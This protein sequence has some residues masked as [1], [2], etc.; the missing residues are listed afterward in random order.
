MSS[1]PWELLPEPFEVGR[2]SAPPMAGNGPAVRGSSVQGFPCRYY[3]RCVLD[4]HCEG[5][6][7]GWAQSWPLAFPTRNGRDKKTPDGRSSQPFKQWPDSGWGRGKGEPYP[8]AAEAYYLHG[9][10]FISNLCNAL[11]GCQSEK[12]RLR[13]L[14]E[15]SCQPAEPDPVCTGGGIRRGSKAGAPILLNFQ[16]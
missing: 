4:E 12:D 14:K 6:R 10:S 3:D 11:T 16:L 15:K 8:G 5:A 1:F 9:K 13:G 2:G 7:F